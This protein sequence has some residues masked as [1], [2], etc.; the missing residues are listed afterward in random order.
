[1]ILHP[2]A[3]QVCSALLACI[4]FVPG[5]PFLPF[6]LLSVLFFFLAR[7]A[8]GEVNR[9]ADEKVAIETAEKAKGEGATDSV[10]ALLH[11]DVLALE[12]GVGLIPLVDSQQDGEILER[13]VSARKQ[14][15]QD[16]GIVVPM[17]M[18]RDN[19]QLKP[20][21]YQ[22][23]LKGNRIGGG[24]LMVDYHLAM[25]P[26][27]ISEPIGGIA[28]KEPAYGLDAIWI[29]ASQKDEATFRGYTV[30]NCATVIV[31]HLTKLIQDHAHELIGRQEVQSLIDGV[32]SH[33]PKVIEE[34]IATDRMTLGDVVKVLQNLLQEGVSI[35]DSLTVFETLA[36][37][38]K[39]IKNPD[40]L[41][42]FVRIAMGRGIVRKYLAP[43]GRLVVVTLDRAVEDLVVGGLQQFEDGSTSLNIDPE[44][45]QRLLNNIANSMAHFETHGT[46]PILLCGSRIRWDLRRLVARFIPG[47]VVMAF[48]EIPSD[49]NT[50]S[51]GIVTL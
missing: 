37:Y 16:L 33:H 38:C 6:A 23:M 19:I 40:R 18:V 36:D 2:K 41:T 48:D 12:V 3:V 42:R 31:T 4:A 25:D 5:L 13:I 22:I 14:F 32:K 7:Y 30:V 27:E 15:A 46:I 11:V 45:G 29:K 10:E 34:V 50:R 39:T 8:Q 43:D 1:M 20:G 51:V 49:V 21:E 44:I 35:R 47:L 9:R 26:G 28:T 24:N 17:V